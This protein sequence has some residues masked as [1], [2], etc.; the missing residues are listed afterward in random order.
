[1][2]SLLLLSNRQSRAAGAGPEN[3][4]SQ[5]LLQER[6]WAV[7]VSQVP[8]TSWGAFL[9]GIARSYRR[10]KQSDVDV[11]DSH[12]SP[13]ELHIAGLFLSRLLGKPWL[14]EFR[15]PLANNVF[16]E[17]GS[18]S[19]YQRRLLERVVV[20]SA[21]QLVWWDGIQMPDDYFA[22]QYPHVPEAKWAKLPYLGFGG[23]NATKFENAEPKSYGRF[24][25][26]YAGSFYDGL[27][28]PFAFLRG[29][30][31]YVDYY[32]QDIQTLFYGDWNPEYEAAVSEYGLSDYIVPKDPVPHQ[33]LIRVLKGSNIL[34][35]IGGTDPRNRLNVPLKICDYVG[36]RRPI[37]A[38]VDPDFRVAEL[39]SDHQLGLVAAADEPAEIAGMIHEI[40]S[41]G[42]EHDPNEEIFSRFSSEHSMDYFT[43]I[44]SGMLC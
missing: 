5:R 33:D 27:I 12:C 34:L 3:E 21:E 15:D 32:Q 1:V 25:I 24:T 19:Y 14:A 29:L 31:H 42:Y 18:L 36:A 17:R 8:T 9:A 6:G 22:E 16:V 20:R 4:H 40:R 7:R 13:P 10:A 35:H 38:V 43:D 26:T 2:N 41:G 30:K 39:I 28:E 37:L 23:L 11:I 44:L